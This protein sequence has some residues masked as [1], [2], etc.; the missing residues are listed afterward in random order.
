VSARFDT[1]GACERAFYAAFEAQDTDAMMAVWA[2]RAPLVCIHPSGPALTERDAV[3]ASWRQIFAGG[4]AVRFTLN[5]RRT[6]EDGAVSVRHVHENI[7]HGP[8]FR[9]TALVLASNVFVRED[10][11]WRMCVHH[12]SPGP[13]PARTATRSPV[14]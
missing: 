9:D 8:G 1:P 3:A 11:G 4:G 7:H 14:H 5:E 12:A 10:G 2:E 13:A 6:V